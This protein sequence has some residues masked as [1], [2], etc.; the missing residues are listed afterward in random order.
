MRLRLTI[1][2]RLY[3]VVAVV[4]LSSAGSYFFLFRNQF[5]KLK[6][7]TSQYDVL[8]TNFSKIKRDE[9]YLPKLEEEIAQLKTKMEMIHRRIPPNDALP[10]FIEYLSQNAGRTGIKDFSSLSPDPAINLERY[11]LI[12]IKVVFRCRYMKFIEFLRLL[13]TME[14]LV[15]VDSFTLKAYDKNPVEMD[16][17]LSLSIFSMEE[18]KSK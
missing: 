10:E 3:L 7:L 2:M 6:E 15:R 18:F 4:V 8:A 12:P 5:K 1:K 16:V 14:R 17:V 13:E 11:S 9:E